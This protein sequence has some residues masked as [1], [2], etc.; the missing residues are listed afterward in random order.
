[1]WTCLSLRYYYS[2][3][4]VSERVQR[5]IDRLLDEAEAAI[6]TGDWAAVGD[7]A[8]TVLRL[9][10][11]N[12][13][14]LSYLAASERDPDSAGG[15]G[16][17]DTQDLAEPQPPSSSAPD[18]ERRQ[19]TVMFCD[20]Q[21]STALSQQ[22]D[23]EE[24]RDVIR[25]YQEVCA[26]AVG[27]FEGHIAKYLGDGLLVYFGYP[28]AHEDDPQ[29]AVRAGLAILQDMGPLN[30]RLKSDKDL[31]LTVRIGIHTGLVVAGEMGGGDTLEELAIVGETPNI[32]ARIEG[33]AEPDGIAISDVTASLVQGFF[34]CESMGPHDLKGISEPV[35]L[36]RVLE[37]SGAQTRF[38]VAVSTHLTP[39]VGREQEV[40]LLLDRWEQVE[41]GLG[42][43]VLV[44]GEA[45]IGKSRL[46]QGLIDGLAGRPHVFQQHRCSPYHQNSALFPVIESYERWLGFQR[47]DSQEERI[48][49][50]ETA[51]EERSLLTP[52][53]LSLWAGMLSVPL[54]E[55]HPPLDLSPQ[56]QRQKTMELMTQLKVATANEQPVLAVFEDLHWA[57]PTTLE[58]LGL[59][60]EQVATSKVMAILTFRPEFTPPWGSRSH[61]TQIN[62]NCLPQRLA[63]D[64]IARVTG[65]KELPEEVIDQ[66]AS[67]SDEVPLFVEELT[68]MVIESGLLREMDGR[69]EL[70]GPLTDLAIPSTLQDSLTARLDRL[71]EVKEVVQLA[72]VLGREFIYQSI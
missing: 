38:D 47:E 27:R 12:N 5:Q 23:P 33:A 40:G 31:E 39:L 57:D 62:L 48:Q 16:S 43:V 19:L 41:E 9:D 51:L 64:L 6:A 22:L 18:A 65:G 29:R 34:L 7:H 17:P 35:E 36:F 21:G 60:V 50:I 26:G 44:S 68:Q 13:D 8:R 58:F 49:A 66:I 1:M 67:K 2:S 46:L 20:L 55:S 70:T 15:E 28:Q 45:G 72:S 52:E 24:L 3:T 59:L 32:A 25:G 37:E 69:Y 11:E 63:T 10:P 71:G 54:D 42:Q 56:R 61:V 53:A 30:A 14:A 4:M